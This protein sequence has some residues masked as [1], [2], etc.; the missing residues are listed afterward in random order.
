MKVSIEYQDQWSRWIHYQTKNNERDAYRV[1]SR[2]AGSTGKR[3]RL[4]D[5]DGRLLDVV[6]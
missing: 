4:I 2:R 3:H 5:V 1:A 6:G